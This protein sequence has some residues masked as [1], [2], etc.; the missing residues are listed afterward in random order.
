MRVV[1]SARAREDLR[2]I[3]RRSQ[4]HWGN[5]QSVRYQSRLKDRIRQLRLFPNLGPAW[6]GPLDGVRQLVIEH[7]LALYLV[8]PHQ[9]TVLRIVHEK[10]HPD[11]GDIQ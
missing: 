4:E 5:V 6:D 7:H 2:D 3:R 8:G 11:P 10:M 9:I 1:Y